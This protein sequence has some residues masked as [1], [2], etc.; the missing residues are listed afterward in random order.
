MEA[1]K[2][3]INRFENFFT[4]SLAPSS[5]FFVLLFFSDMFFNNSMGYGKVIE[6][7]Q[8]ARSID[9]TLF[10]LFVVLALLTY[11]YV[12][13]IVMQLF[14]YFI[15]EDYCDSL[16]F[17][18]LREEVKRRLSETEKKVLG[19]VGYTDYNLYQVLGFTESIQ[20]GRNYVDEV[21]ALHSVSSAIGVNMAIYYFYADVSL[22]TM[23]YVPMVAFLYFM[24]C[25]LFHKLAKSRY[26][27]RNKRLYL[28]YLLKEERKRNE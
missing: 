10:Y 20:P 8:K 23:M 27:A 22:I 6:F 4:R 16:E 7:L 13:Q 14:D 21:K 15:K 2:P 1:Y 26:K 25:L 12:N 18:E 5:I 9:I 24:I 3:L 11:G 28:N 19:V 17:K